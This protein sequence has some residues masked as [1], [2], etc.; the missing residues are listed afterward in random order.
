MSYSLLLLSGTVIATLLW[1]MSVYVRLLIA[2]SPLSLLPGPP[3]ESFWNGDVV[4]AESN[5]GAVIHRHIIFRKHEAI[6]CPA[7]GRLSETCRCRFWSCRQN[8]CISWCTLVDHHCDSSPLIKLVLD[9]AFQRPLLYV[10]DPRALHNILIKEE[11][12]FQEQEVF[13]SC[14][15]RR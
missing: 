13:V 10:S 5:I 6:P 3:R 12:I 15:L 11:H 4:F 1:R 7:C 14:V 8:V 2:S 9:C